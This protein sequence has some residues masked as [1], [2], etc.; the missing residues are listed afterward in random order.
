MMQRSPHYAILLTIAALA[1]PLSAAAAQPSFLTAQ[2]VEIERAADVFPA[3]A[4]QFLFARDGETVRAWVF[5]TDKGAT[6]RDQFSRLASAVSVSDRV[7]KR[8]A[9]VGR[10][11]VLFA[12]LPVAESYVR[13]VVQTGADLRRT[14][15]WLN[16]ASVEA[17]LPTLEAVAE[18]PFVARIQPLAVF[19]KPETEVS[20]VRLDRPDVTAQAA[21]AIAYGYA[22]DQVEQINVP[23]VHEK[24]YT[25]A[26]VI[27][28]I[29]DTGYRKSHEAFEQHF[30][31][32][33]VIAEYDFVFNDGN[34]AYEEG[35]DWYSSMNHGTYIWST[36]AGLKP[37]TLVG[38]AYGASFLLAKTEDVRSETIVE[39]DNWVAA[40]EWADS[41][42]ADVLTSSLG[43][44]DWYET[45]DMDGATAITTLAANTAAGLGIVVCNSMGNSGPGPTTLTA[46]ADAYD[47]LAVG[48]VDAS[49]QVAA[50]SSRGPTADPAARIKPEVVARGV[51]TSCA[52]NSGDASYSTASGTSLSTP[53]VAGA[54]CL[55]VEARPTFP[56][57]LIRQA[58]METADRATEP[59]NAYGWGLIDV[60]SALTW[61]VNFATDIELAQA[62]QTVQ[63]TDLSTLPRTSW[64]WD[65]GDGTTSTEQNPTHSYAQPGAYD[66]SLSIETVDYGQMTTQKLN[67]IIL[68]GDTLDYGPDSVFAGEPV[69]FSV[70][71]TN[72]QEL[73]RIVI[74]I[75]FEDAYWLNF[76]SIS[77]GSRTA[78]FERL[79]TIMADPNNNRYVM[80]L[81]ADIGGGTP[82]LAPGSGEVLRIHFSTD[83]YAFGGLG[84]NVDSLNLTGY[85]VSLQ[86]DQLSYAPEVHG[87]DLLLRTV[88]RGDPDNSLAINVADITYMVAYLFNGG[89]QPVSVQAGDANRD[90]LINISDVTYLVDYLFKA[91]PPPPTP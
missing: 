15:K 16:A 36:S 84:V 32:G 87:G 21:D 23:P 52:V 58:L 63:F 39:E 53:L 80:E 22:Q 49:G 10:D 47:I 28:A 8:R 59:D 56:P 5:F 4:E 61:G 41:L 37:G 44:S 13:Q 79:R 45:S 62:P 27:L 7:M 11:E 1:L 90:F 3:P 67:H 40:L 55:L 64:E 68:L 30:L 29:L 66:I 91:G 70:D 77:P 85:S 78:S 19:T 18:L 82:P 43:Y 72:S 48:A 71:L 89:P 73:N 50:F 6:S 26:G 69:V 57:T 75:T 33:R 81:Q 86:S 20:P 17:S 9:K 2:P 65:F 14:S 34:T 60:D 38:P 76:D 83:A 35:I 74:P 24:G 42:G 88:L 46:P 31:D 54:A 51:S 12:D 25:G